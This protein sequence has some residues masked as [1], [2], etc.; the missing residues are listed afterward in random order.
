MRLEGLE[1]TVINVYNPRGDNSQIR[2]WPEVKTAIEEAK[3]EI[4]LLGDFNAHHPV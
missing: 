2:A 4:I 3:G 1:V